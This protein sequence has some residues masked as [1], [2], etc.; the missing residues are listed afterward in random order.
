MENIMAVLDT[1][2]FA[3]PALAVFIVQITLYILITLYIY[4]VPV[5]KTP[6]SGLDEA[7][8]W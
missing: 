4:S 6:P 8:D 3:Y 2:W 5:S 1:A 7:S